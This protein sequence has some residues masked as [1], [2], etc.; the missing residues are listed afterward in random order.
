MLRN[1]FSYPFSK[2]AKMSHQHENTEEFVKVESEKQPEKCSQ[3]YFF[4]INSIEAADET[5]TSV[6]I[7]ISIEINSATK[8][9]TCFVICLKT[10]C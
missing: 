8:C 1:D 6:S 9:G 5:D 7:A 2:F 10:F 4:F 3:F